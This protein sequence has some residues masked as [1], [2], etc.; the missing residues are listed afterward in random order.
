MLSYDIKTVF[1]V[2]TYLK[3]SGLSGMAYLGTSAT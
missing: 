2:H 1:Q 3:L